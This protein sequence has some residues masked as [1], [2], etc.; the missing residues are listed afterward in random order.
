MKTAKRTQI[1]VQHCKLRLADSVATAGAV[2]AAV[3]ADNS[4]NN[5]GVE[6]EDGCSEDE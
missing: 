1:L 5:E 2:S 4:W 3:G 6:E